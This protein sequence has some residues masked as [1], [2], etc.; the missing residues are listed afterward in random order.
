MHNLATG[1]S[2]DFG[3]VA[4]S[5]ISKNFELILN[6][7]S[8]IMCCCHDD[9]W[10]FCCMDKLYTCKW[11]NLQILPQGGQTKLTLSCG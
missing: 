3:F 7:F 8:Q 1:K 11:A 5:V 2:E 4:E 9:I 6:S 10:G